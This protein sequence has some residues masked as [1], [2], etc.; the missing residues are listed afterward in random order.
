M[1]TPAYAQRA[2]ALSLKEVTED[3]NLS[4][5]ARA[6]LIVKLGR[7]MVGAIPRARLRA[8][9]KAVKERLEDRKAVA[10]GKIVPAPDAAPID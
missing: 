7:A 5:R 8:A 10:G 9:E 6:E 1:D 2:Y 3:P 4:S